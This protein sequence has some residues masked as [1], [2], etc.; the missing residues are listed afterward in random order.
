MTNEEAIEL[1]RQAGYQ[2]PYAVGECEDFEYF[3]IES[4]AKLVAKH[5][6][7]NIDPSKFTSWQD[8]FEVGVQKSRQEFDVLFAEHQKLLGE[9]EAI[10]KVKQENAGAAATLDEMRRRYD[11]H[12]AKALGDKHDTR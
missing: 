2:H 9:L 7:L 12:F 8:G 10:K 3:D 11:E 5:T 6:L 1:A 4:F